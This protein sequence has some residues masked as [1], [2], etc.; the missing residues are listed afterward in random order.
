MA[1]AVTPT[2]SDATARPAGVDVACIDFITDPAVC[3][4][5]RGVGERSHI[6]TIITTM[7]LVAAGTYMHPIQ[8]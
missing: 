4:V 1:F 3:T 6:I 5:K 7:T 2:T 8:R